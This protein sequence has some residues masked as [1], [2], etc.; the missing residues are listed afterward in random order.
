[1][2]GSREQA[3]GSNL[4]QRLPKS[5]RLQRVWFAQSARF[6]PLKLKEPPVL[7]SLPCEYSEHIAESSLPGL[8]AEQKGEPVPLG[9]KDARVTVMNH[10]YI[11]NS[12]FILVCFAIPVATILSQQPAVTDPSSA[13]ATAQEGSVPSSQQS[14]TG[15]T[16]ITIQQGT[17]FRLNVNLVQVHVTVRDGKG[18]AISGLH[19]EDFLLYDQGK[20]QPIS[21]FAV[22]T[23]ESRLE[24]AQAA[25]KTQEMGNQLAVEAGGAL[26]DRFI[27]LLFDDIHL[28]LNDAEFARTQVYKFLDGVRPTERVGIFSSSGELTHD[29]TADK[30]A[31]KQ[32][33]LGLIPRPRFPVDHDRCPGMTYYDADQ[34]QNRSNSAVYNAMVQWVVDKCPPPQ[35]HTPQEARA[36]AEVIVRNLV[37]VVLQ[38]GD[39]ES[40]IVYRFLEDSLRMLAGRPGDRVMVL[41]SPGFLTTVAQYLDL[42]GVIDRANQFNI[43][44]NTLDPRGLYSLNPM[45]DISDN[46]NFDENVAGLIASFNNDAR[47]RQGDVLRDFAYGTGG[48]YYGNSNDLV[49]G[50]NQLAAVPEV[51]YVLGFAPQSQ[52]MDGAFHELKVRLGQKNNYTI[53]ARRGYFLP[54]RSNDPAEQEHEEIVAAVFSRDEIQ[55]LL[56]QI[57]TRYFKAD[58]AQAH[59]SVVSRIDLNG[60]HVRKADGWAL[61]NLTVVTVIFDD[62]G[63]YISGLQK[64]LQLKLTESDY[65]RYLRMGLAVK[66]DFELKPGRYLVRQI[67]RDSEGAQMAARNGSV[68]IPN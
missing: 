62:N 30:D 10:S 51:S 42:S 37:P 60:V 66:S 38:Q 65:Q 46:R 12:L 35:Y 43:V 9:Y 26:P 59:L 53:Q 34:I 29:F 2:Q 47:L 17:T 63:N 48:I 49:A 3:E 33:L 32:T 21:T 22:E 20:L 41:A 25:A 64:V 56:L 61:D 40:Q 55:D 52:K 1:M 5:R 44:I 67:V 50:L 11:P 13:S 16:E 8:A 14:A 27:A 45:G 31:L 68:E 28:S 4:W 57:Q 6:V 24:K 36:G 39:A 15:K 58:A 19:K 23:R 54:R 7:N 18:N